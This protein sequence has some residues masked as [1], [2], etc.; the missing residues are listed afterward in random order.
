MKTIIE[1]L[2][3]VASFIMPLFNISLILH[4]LKRKSSDDISLVWL[5][6]VWGCILLM[7]P[8]ALTSPDKA[9]WVFGVMNIVF[10]TLVVIV[11]LYYRVNR[12]QRE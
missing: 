12:V 10:F 8:A 11:S 3:V 5:L 2:G 1:T 6:G 7:T 4:I 9:F